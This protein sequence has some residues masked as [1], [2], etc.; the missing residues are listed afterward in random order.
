MSISIDRRGVSELLAEGLKKR[1]QCASLRDGN[2]HKEVNAHRSTHGVTTMSQD[3][4]KVQQMPIDFRV[5]GDSIDVHIV[6]VW[7]DEASVDWWMKIRS[8]RDIDI[9]YELEVYHPS[10]PVKDPV[11]LILDL[12]RQ[13]LELTNLGFS[14]GLRL[15]RVHEL[16]KEL[17]ERL[18]FHYDVVPA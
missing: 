1:L 15:R 14:T 3:H 17:A 6:Q 11:D 5:N 16:V 12:G 7:R 10:L 9:F 8:P 13:S 2:S 4:G 18:K